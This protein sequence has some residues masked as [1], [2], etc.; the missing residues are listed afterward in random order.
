MAMDI[1]PFDFNGNEIRTLGTWDAPLFVAADVC[2]VL[3]LSNV[4]KAC[5]SLDDDEKLI[6]QL[7]ISGQNRDVICVTESGLYSLVLR[8]RKKQAKVFKKWITSKVIPSIRKTG[9]YIKPMSP[10]E[11][12]MHQAQMM[13]EMEQ[14]QNA[15]ELENQ[16]LRMEQEQIRAEHN[17]LHDAV[18]QHDAEIGRIFEPDG[19]MITLAG[20]LNLHGKHATAAELSPVGRKASKAYRE[21]YEQDPPKLGDARFGTVAAYPQAIAEQA[22]RECGYI[23]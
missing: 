13:L 8:S 20:C 23:A 22:L 21:K 10:A 12:M 2:A 14:R 1:V 6:S 17:L 5:E 16:R 3:D 7:V 4:S 18:V 11:M 15:L 19:M 9:S